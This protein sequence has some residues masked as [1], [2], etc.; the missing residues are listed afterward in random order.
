M[1]IF[2]YLSIIRFCGFKSRD[3]RLGLTP[4]KVGKK[5]KNF[6]NLNLFDAPTYTYIYML[7]I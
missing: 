3:C 6:C 4:T 7:N 5:L 1:K 2:K